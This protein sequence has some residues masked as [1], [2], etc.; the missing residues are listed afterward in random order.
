MFSLKK[1]CQTKVLNVQEKLSI[2]M[3]LHY[4]HPEMQL[5]D[6]TSKHGI[7]HSGPNFVE[8]L[9]QTNVIVTQCQLL[10]TRRP[11][12]FCKSQ[13]TL[14]LAARKH[15]LSV[16]R[17]EE[18]LFFQSDKSLFKKLRNFLLY[19]KHRISQRPAETHVGTNIHTAVFRWDSIAP[20]S[21][22]GLLNE[23]I[24]FSDFGDSYCIYQACELV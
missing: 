17:S 1:G 6:R 13:E 20:T 2:I 7:F 18:S 4:K 23:W 11:A 12:K 3:M 9:P 15:Q 14:F 22:S 24:M 19:S 10:W 16:R 8:A 5:H 21:V